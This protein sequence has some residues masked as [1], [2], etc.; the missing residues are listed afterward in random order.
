M[1]SH[2]PGTPLLLLLLMAVVAVLLLFA[3]EAKAEIRKWRHDRRKK[4]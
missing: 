4:M 1:E 2:S 3:T